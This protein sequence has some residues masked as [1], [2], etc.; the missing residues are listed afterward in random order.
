MPKI[1]L[2]NCNMYLT[3]SETNFVTDFVTVFVA[4]C[5]RYYEKF[6]GCNHDL[7]SDRFCEKKNCDRFCDVFCEKF[8]VL[9]CPIC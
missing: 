6:C 8:Y 3:K 7:L 2:A 4:D 5:N 1:S 9:L